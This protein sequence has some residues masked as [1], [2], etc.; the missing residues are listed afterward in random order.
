MKNSNTVVLVY[1]EKE[2]RRKGE[3][4]FRGGRGAGISSPF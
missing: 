4:S 3:T 2:K 1:G